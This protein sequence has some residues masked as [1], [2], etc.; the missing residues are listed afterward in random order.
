M[1][2]VTEIGASALGWTAASI[3]EEYG[4]E[5]N[6]EKTA[7]LQTWIS[8]QA[9]SCPS[10]LW[11]LLIKALEQGNFFIYEMAFRNI[12]FASRCT[13]GILS[14]FAKQLLKIILDLPESVT[15]KKLFF[16]QAM[17]LIYYHPHPESQ[18][19]LEDRGQAPHY[20]L[21]EPLASSAHIIAACG[22][23]E[24]FKTILLTDWMAKDKYGQTPVFYA[25][26]LAGRDRGTVRALVDLARMGQD[27]TTLAR[28][29][30]MLTAERDELRKTLKKSRSDNQ[31]IAMEVAELKKAMATTEAMTL[32]L[33]TALEGLESAY[34]KKEAD[35]RASFDG[36]LQYQLKKTAQ[37]TKRIQELEK[38][39]DDQNGLIEKLKKEIQRFLSRSNSLKLTKQVADYAIAPNPEESLYGIEERRGIAELNSAA[40]GLM[41]ELREF[42][43]SQTLWSSPA[44]LLWPGAC[45]G[46]GMEPG[47]KPALSS[48]FHPC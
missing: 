6:A 21:F 22:S 15:D 39:I 28:E 26:H 34:L 5:R 35:L 43:I 25:T 7:R 46:A 1:S 48:V 9:S 10:V 2:G 19:W 12:R 33:K 32:S 11:D 4:G 27:L 16:K 3:L 8:N 13:L 14:G 42:R 37:S 24:D 47:F 44:A 20:N 45:S 38:K 30:K 18:F 17:G 31:C 23:H 36:R 41:N 40:C 29:V